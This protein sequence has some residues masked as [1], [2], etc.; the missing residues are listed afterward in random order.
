MNLLPTMYIQGLIPFYMTCS[1]EEGTH[2]GSA[3]ALDPEDM[4]FGQYREVG[5]LIWRGFSLEQAMNNCFGTRLEPSKGRQMPIHYGSKEHSYQ[6]VSSPL[7]TQMPQGNTSSLTGLALEVNTHWPTRP[8][9][10]VAS[11]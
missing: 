10:S 7:S 9:G 1:G 3:A 4:V 5:V 11:S 6:F 8:V 2:F